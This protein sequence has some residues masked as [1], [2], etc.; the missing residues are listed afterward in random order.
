MCIVKAGLSTPCEDDDLFKKD[1]G[2][3]DVCDRVDVGVQ[4]YHCAEL[5]LERVRQEKIKHI[6]I[7]SVPGQC[8][9]IGSR[10]CPGVVQ[11]DL[12]I[13]RE[14]VPRGAIVDRHGDEPV[15]V[16]APCLIVHTC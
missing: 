5:V 3:R 15:P 16:E 13:V 10:M 7:L 2:N 11:R 12:S 14:Q 6:I 8:V 9:H 1:R 4:E